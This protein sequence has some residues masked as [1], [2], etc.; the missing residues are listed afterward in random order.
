MRVR[1]SAVIELESPQ[2]TGRDRF[3]NAAHRLHRAC[4]ASAAGGRRDFKTP[5]RSGGR[6]P[7]QSFEFRNQ[8]LECFEILDGRH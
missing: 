1:R 2:R 6:L 3:R 4:H 7:G 8:M 5:R